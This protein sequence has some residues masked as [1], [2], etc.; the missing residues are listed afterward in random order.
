MK[1]CLLFLS[2]LFIFIATSCAK[3]K[4]VEIDGS[5]TVFPIT[6]A[7]AVNFKEKAK[8]IRVTVG[9]SGT[10]GGF[11][12]FCRGET[13]ISG[14]SRP[15]KESEIELCKQNKINYIELPIA[16]DGL[17]VVVH[18]TNTWAKSIKVSELKKLWEPAAKGKILKWSDLRAGWPNKEIHLFG[19]GTDSGTFDYF[20]SAIVGKEGMSRGDYTSSED[21]NVLVQG[22]A[23]DPLALGYFGFA[24]Y[25]EN[26]E[27]KNAKPR[28]SAVAI[29]SETGKPPIVSSFET[30]SNGTYQPLSRP[31]FIYVNS[32]A[33]NRSEVKDFVAFY[34]EQSSTKLIRTVGYIN[35]PPVALRLVKDRFTNRTIGT[36]FNGAKA[37]TTVEKVLQ[38]KK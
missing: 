30:V 37:G 5:S 32:D 21:D 1:F 31:I 13:V 35:L 15:I 19:P 36:V 9:I 4:F 10:G 27:D 38:A 17:T 3:S 18:P 16:Y 11:K 6:E 33:L 26:R 28:L 2:V 12:R 20:T 14:A 34:L 7:V 24:Y 8:D 23:T 25:W 22:V 29:D